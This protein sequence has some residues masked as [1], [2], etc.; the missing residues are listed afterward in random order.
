MT[1]LSLLTFQPLCQI[2][3]HLLSVFTSIRRRK[4]QVRNILKKT[5]QKT[6]ELDQLPTPLIYEN[7]DLLLPALTNIINRSLLSREVPSEFKTAVVKPLLKK[8]SLDLKQMKKISPILESSISVKYPRKSCPDAAHKSSYT[9]F[10]LPIVP[11]TVQKQVS[12]VSSMI[13]SQLLMPTKFLSSLP[14]SGEL[15]TQKLRSHLVRTQSLNV[16]PS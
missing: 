4:K 11:I 8:A 13:F 15:R 16:L 3:Q 14:R 12:F 1:T 6:H 5:P 9:N 7:I 2:W 10:D